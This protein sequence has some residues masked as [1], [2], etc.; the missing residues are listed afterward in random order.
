MRVQVDRV[1]TG[2][3]ESTYLQAREIGIDCVA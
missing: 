2:V 3:L 1:E